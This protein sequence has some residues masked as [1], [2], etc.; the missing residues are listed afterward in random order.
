MENQLVLL[1]SS[2]QCCVPL[3]A[4]DRS[5]S[6]QTFV[7]AN[8][9]T[10]HGGLPV[11]ST[12]TNVWATHSTLASA[13]ALSQPATYHFLL[14]LVESGDL[15]SFDVVR[16]DLW[17]VPDATQPLVVWDFADPTTAKLVDSG[18]LWWVSCATGLSAQI[19]ELLFAPFPK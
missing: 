13:K 7:S 8:A 18:A 12:T 16:S 17:P 1:F 14:S 19:S 6:R 4:I 2:S 10:V 9:T 5:F 11:V 3:Q 15:I